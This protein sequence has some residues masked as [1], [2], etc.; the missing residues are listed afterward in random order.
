MNTLGLLLILSIPLIYWRKKHQQNARLAF[1]YQLY[2]I[3][4]DL[5]KAAIQGRVSKQSV[6][7]QYFDQNLSLLINQSYYY[8]LFKVLFVAFSKNKSTPAQIK[9]NQQLMAEVKASSLLQSIQNQQLNTIRHYL[10]HQHFVT[11]NLLVK[12]LLLL[13]FGPSFLFSKINGYIQETFQFPQNIHDSKR[14]SY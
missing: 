10:V 11:S 1:K 3:R 12:P 5:R 14:V 7:F 6:G 9:L 4:D 8:T 13:V 2:A